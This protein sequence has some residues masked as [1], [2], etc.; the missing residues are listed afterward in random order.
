[1]LALL[2]LTRSDISTREIELLRD[3]PIEQR[4]LLVQKIIMEHAYSYQQLDQAQEGMSCSHCY[5]Q[6]QY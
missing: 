3:A 1:M 4:D 6:A 2:G 5:I